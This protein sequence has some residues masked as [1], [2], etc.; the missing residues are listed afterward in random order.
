MPAPPPPGNSSAVVNQAGRA[1]NFLNLVVKAKDASDVLLDP[2]VHPVEKVVQVARLGYDA[3]NL[4]HSEHK[5]PTG[6]GVDDFIPE[7]NNA[8]DYDPNNYF[9]DFYEGMRD[10]G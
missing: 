7:R 10:M 6:A 9:E 4:Y 3:Y 8:R 5:E 1:S 2:N